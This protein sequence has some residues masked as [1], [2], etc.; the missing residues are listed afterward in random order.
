MYIYTVTL[1]NMC[2]RE[3]ERN[4]EEGLICPCPIGPH[5]AFLCTSPTTTPQPPSQPPFLFIHPHMSNQAAVHPL[6]YV[7][8]HS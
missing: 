4:H 2:L 5:P 8:T 3:T 7:Y 6:C 1:F